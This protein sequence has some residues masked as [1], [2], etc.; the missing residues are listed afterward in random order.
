[1]LKLVNITLPPSH[2]LRHGPQPPIKPRNEESALCPYSPN[3]GLEYAPGH[4]G[5]MGLKPSSTLQDGSL[6]ARPETLGDGGPS[7][8]SD[9]QPTVGFGH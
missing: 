8:S 2:D 4:L 3:R 7:Q 5:Q 9:Q 1:M 6:P